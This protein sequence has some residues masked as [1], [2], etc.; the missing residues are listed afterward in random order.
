MTQDEIEAWSRHTVEPF[1]VHMLPGDHFFVSSCRLPLL[2]L[3]T[4]QLTIQF[5]D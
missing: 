1:Q 2:R 3:I 4:E 5:I